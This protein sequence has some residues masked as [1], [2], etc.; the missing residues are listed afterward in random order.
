MHLQKKDYEQAQ[1]IQRELMKRC[2]NDKVIAEFSK[3][4]PAEIE[5]QR[6]NKEEEEEEY[7]D[8]EEASEEE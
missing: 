3:F 4:L 5:E 8:E 7:Y 2:P 6:A 1:A